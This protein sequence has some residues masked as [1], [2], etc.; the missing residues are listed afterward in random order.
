MEFSYIKNYSVGFGYIKKKTLSINTYFYT[1]Q[2][3]KKV[4]KNRKK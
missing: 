2:L 3:Q 1:L 4:C